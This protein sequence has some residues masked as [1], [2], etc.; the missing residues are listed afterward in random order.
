MK[1]LQKEGYSQQDLLNIKKDATNFKD[2]DY[3]KSQTPRG[4][5]TKC[6]EVQGFMSSCKESAAKVERL[7]REVRYACN[8]CSSMHNPAKFLN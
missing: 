8:T 7:H 2:L 3:L 6:A 4:P 1:K 5:F